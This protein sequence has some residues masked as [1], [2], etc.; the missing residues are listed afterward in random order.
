[1]PRDNRKLDA[2]ITN[3]MGQYGLTDVIE[4]PAGLAERI[5]KTGIGYAERTD[6]SLMVCFVINEHKFTINKEDAIPMIK[7]WADALEAMT[8]EMEG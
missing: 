6:G 4:G 2:A 3:R 5:E 8:P 7:M 1:M